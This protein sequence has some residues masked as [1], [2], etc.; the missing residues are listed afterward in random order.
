MACFDDT[1]NIVA[2]S[3]MYMPGWMDRYVAFVKRHT[4]L[5]PGGAV[6]RSSGA[7]GS[8]PQ[9]SIDTAPLALSVLKS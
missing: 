2:A 4:W 9:P 1:G 3:R 6:S 5:D 8:T 7:G